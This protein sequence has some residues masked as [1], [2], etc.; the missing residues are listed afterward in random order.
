MAGGS[1]LMHL[2]QQPGDLEVS[3][4][5]LKDRK[6]PGAALGWMKFSLCFTFHSVTFLLGP[7]GQTKARIKWGGGGGIG[8]KPG[9]CSPL[10]GVLKEKCPHLQAIGIQTLLNGGEKKISKPYQT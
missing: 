3:N 1:S 7:D 8:S 5:Y 6:F 9:K 10:L 4:F 2:F